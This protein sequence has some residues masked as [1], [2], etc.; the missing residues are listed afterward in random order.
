MLQLAR[1]TLIEREAL[2]SVALQKKSEG[3]ILKKRMTNNKPPFDLRVIVTA[4]SLF[5]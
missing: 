2:G 5:G 3:L 4:I 1:S